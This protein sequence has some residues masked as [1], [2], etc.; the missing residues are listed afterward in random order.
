MAEIFA[1][2]LAEVKSSHFQGWQCSSSVLRFSEK[3]FGL[4]ANLVVQSITENSG[5]K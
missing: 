4:Q 1:L 2:E 5:E 3:S